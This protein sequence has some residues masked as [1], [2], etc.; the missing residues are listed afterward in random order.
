MHVIT[1]GPDMHA[2]HILFFHPKGEDSI[3]LRKHGS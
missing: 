1:E 3:G 2:A